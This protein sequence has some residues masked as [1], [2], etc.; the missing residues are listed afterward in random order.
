MRRE[1]PVDIDDEAGDHGGR[2][3][4]DGEAGNH[5]HDAC[6]D[7]HHEAGNHYHDAGDDDHHE[8]ANHYDHNASCGNRGADDHHGDDSG[9]DHD[10]HGPNRDAVAVDDDARSAGRSHHRAYADDP[11]AVGYCSH[12]S[13]RVS[14]RVAPSRGGKPGCSIEPVR[15]T[16]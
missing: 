2:P 11:E 3:G 4:D 13:K 15:R 1:G 10:G 12:E 5:R 6:G 7:H 9:D 16:P 14:E 8:V